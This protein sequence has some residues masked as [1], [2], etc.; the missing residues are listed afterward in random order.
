L[1]VKAFESHK[2]GR[3][4]TFTLNS[5]LVLSKNYGRN[6]FIKLTPGSRSS[7]S[8]LHLPRTS[9]TTKSSPIRTSCPRPFS[10]PKNGWWRRP[11][12]D[13]A[14][15]ESRNQKKKKILCLCTC[16]RAVIEVCVLRFLHR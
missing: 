12:D 11:D 9:P 8:W 1:F 6:W 5:V 13:V 14:R 7:V 2:I 3:K 15:E 10:G 4:L 16:W